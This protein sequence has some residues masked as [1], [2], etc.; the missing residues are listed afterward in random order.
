MARSAIHFM[1]LGAHTLLMRKSLVINSTV[2]TMTIAHS[3]TSARIAYK[4][5]PTTT[6]AITDIDMFVTATGTLGGTNWV[7]QVESDSS[8]APSGTILGAATSEFTVSATGFTG[9]KSLG[10]NTGALTINTPVWIV[11]KYSSGTAPQTATC[12][13]QAMGPGGKIQ[14]GRWRLYGGDWTST[15]AVNTS[16]GFMVLKHADGS[17]DGYGHNTANAT[18]T[19]TST[20][21]GGTAMSGLRFQVGAPTK[22]YGGIFNLVRGAGAAGLNAVELCLFE[23]TNA[24]PVANNTLA[25][26]DTPVSTN[27]DFSVYFSTPYTLLPNVQYFLMLHQTSN[28]GTAAAVNSSY[29]FRRYTVSNTAYLE[30]LMAPN[31]AFCTGNYGNAPPFTDIASNT[32]IPIIAAIVSDPSTDFQLGVV[33]NISQ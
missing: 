29:Q 17:Y 20:Y 7:M 1:Q 26:S 2:S 33:P 16:D 31:T 27:T 3:T 30:T 10:S 21:I 13:I 9:L 23:G 19:T 25:V 11:F 6:S 24:T 18:T 22:I 8:D 28:G 4:Y 32:E 5:Y 12:T 14:S 15:A